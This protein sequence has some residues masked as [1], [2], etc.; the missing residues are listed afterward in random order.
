[1]KQI[2]LLMALFAVSCVMSSLNVKA[3]NQNLKNISIPGL[4]GKYQTGYYTKSEDSPQYAK[5]DSAKDTLSGNERAIMAKVTTGSTKA[6]EIP[7]GKKVELDKG[8]G[9]VELKGNVF[10]LELTHKSP[11]V[12]GSTFNGTWYLN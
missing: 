6:V 5:K 11:Y 2:K 10:Q 9:L 7:K 4:Y 12:T 3:A 1:M 8:T